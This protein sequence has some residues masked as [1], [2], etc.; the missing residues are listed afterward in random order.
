M[1]KR[2]IVAFTLA[3]VIS[4]SEF[5][6]QNLLVVNA[7][8][9]MENKESAETYEEEKQQ[10]ENENI[11]NENKIQTEIVKSEEED[12]NSFDDDVYLKNEENN[13]TAAVLARS[14]TNYEYTRNSTTNQIT[15]T[16]YTGDE[17]KIVIPSSIDGYKV[18]GIG[19]GVFGDLDN[20]VSVTIPE[21]VKTIENSAFYDCDNSKDAVLLKK[22]L[23]GYTGL[24]IDTAAADVNMDGGVDSKDA[25]KMLRHLAGY[26]VKLGE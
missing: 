3:M 25:V 4:V 10:E 18:E 7:G 13:I 2:K 22:Y 9:E 26:E 15:I 6:M 23:A 20:L 17:T 11:D 19:N 16:K 14:N 12:K 8:Q 5:Q 24:D 21:N 1:R